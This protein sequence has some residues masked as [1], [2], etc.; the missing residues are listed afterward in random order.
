[1]RRTGK[2]P[3][4]VEGMHMRKRSKCSLQILFSRKEEEWILR[5]ERSQV[6]MALMA[7]RTQDS[8]IPYG[9]E[10]DVFASNQGEFPR[11]DTSL[12]N[13]GSSVWNKPSSPHS[14]TKDI[15]RDPEEE[16]QALLGDQ[17]SGDGRSCMQPSC[18]CTLQLC[19]EYSKHEK[20]AT[21]TVLACM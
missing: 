4:G 19:F 20:N 3:R 5:W 9:H 18:L 14:R 21:Q 1:M 15:P 17:W 6:C 16:G 13:S 8:N 12:F 11:T 10:A 2:K 7:R